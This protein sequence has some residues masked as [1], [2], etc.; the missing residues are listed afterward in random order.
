MLQLPS[1][2]SVRV[3]SLSSSQLTVANVTQPVMK[4][5][6]KFE[7]AP[8]GF[9]TATWA[10]P[11][12]VM[13]LA[14]TEAVSC[15]ELTNVVVRGV[16]FHCTVAPER[17]PVPFTVSV[18]S[19]PPA[20]VEIGL[21]LVMP[22]TGGL[23]VK[24]SG[25]EV[26]PELDTVT[27]AVPCEVMRVEATVAVI[28]VGL[29]K[30]VG[31]GVLFHSTVA[32]KKNPV[33]FTVSVN[34]APPAA[35]EVGLRLVMTGSG[36]LIG[37]LT[38]F[39]AAA[40]GLITVMLALPTALTRLAGTEAISCVELPKVVERDEPVHCTVAPE[41]KPVPFTVSEK[42]SPVAVAELGLRLVMVAA[43][44]GFTVTV[45]DW[46]IAV[47]LGLVTVRV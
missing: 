31:N 34:A 12:A 40:P 28:W 30:V 6:P 5:V 42:A 9:V 38:A 23:I 16:P 13:R 46:V 21:R 19:P 18:K 26:T 36:W 24:L 44:T 41:R 2:F 15:V 32:P 39:D 4:K 45:A 47:P 25:F 27:V 29:T 14:E 10:L 7:T 17:S 8:S 11:I 33:P 1:L 22:G 3:S 20:A 43:G 35:A 37:K